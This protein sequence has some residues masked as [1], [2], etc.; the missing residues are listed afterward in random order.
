MRIAIITKSF[1]QSNNDNAMPP[2]IDFVQSVSGKIDIDVYALYY[3]FERRSYRVFGAQIH[4]FNLGSQPRILRKMHRLGIQKKI[5]QEHAD[6]PYD[7]IHAIW[8]DE[9]AVLA[10]RVSSDL[11][12]PMITTFYAG[13]AVYIPEIN[14]GSLRSPKSRESL[15]KVLEL[16]AASTCGSR[17]LAGEIASNTNHT[18]LVV[19]FG[20]NVERFSPAPSKMKLEGSTTIITA[21]SFSA[22]KGLDIL[23]NAFQRL[24]VDHPSLAE[25]LHWHI[26]GPDAGDRA[27]RNSLFAQTANLPITLHE[28]KPYWDM[29]EFYRAGDVVWHGSWFESQCFAALEPAACG[30]PV[31]GTAVGVIPEM[32]S[33]DWTCVPGD[34]SALKNLL[35]HVLSNRGKWANEAARQHQWVKDNATLKIAADRFEKIYVQFAT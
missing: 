35:V 27:L 28:A 31:A 8:A 30:V 16:S 13:E 25:G 33:P 4:S 23:L 11:N 20:L 19:P 15:Q 24:I 22:V 2:L 7:L 3:P 21:A 17:L 26:I 5:A 29:P 6:R 1:A 12:I 34:P 14:Y 18:P 9:S 32:A 10:A